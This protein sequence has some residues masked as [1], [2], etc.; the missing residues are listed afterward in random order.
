MPRQAGYVPRDLMV[1]DRESGVRK[2]N[3][4][5]TDANNKYYLPSKTRT[6]E[7]RKEA[8]DLLKGKT[9][10]GMKVKAKAPAK[11]VVAKA[12]TKRVTK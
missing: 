1:L 11:P 6:K 12:V 2:E 7:L 8:D 3:P 10:F 4:L 9:G 5:L